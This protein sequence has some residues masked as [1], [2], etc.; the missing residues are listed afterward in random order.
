MS[1]ISQV[2]FL[3]LTSI[4]AGIPS[5]SSTV[6]LTKAVDISASYPV[7]VVVYTVPSLSSTQ[8][9][10]KSIRIQ[11]KP[12]LCHGSSCAIPTLCILL[13]CWSLRR[14]PVLLVCHRT[15]RGGEIMDFALSRRLN[16]LRIATLTPAP[17][18]WY[19]YT[20]LK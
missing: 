5:T 9:M 6:W 7:H 2:S 8:Q 20:E 11:F 19:N 12:T 16:L 3:N 13:G 17:N 15:I 18:C 10:H 14:P 4:K 1:V